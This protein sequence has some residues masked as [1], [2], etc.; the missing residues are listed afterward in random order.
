MSIINQIL[1]I[2]ALLLSVQ[3]YA[4]SAF[5]NGNVLYKEGKYKEAVNAYES[6]LDSGKESPEVYFNLGNAYYKLNAIAPSIY[7]Y[8]KAL[9]LKPNFKDAIIN[10]GYAEKMTIDN[11]QAVPEV[12][13]SKILYNFTGTYHYDTWAWAA[14]VCAVLF[15]LLFTGYYFAGTTM[16]KRIFFTGMILMLINIIITIISAFFVK[17]ESEKQQPAIVFDEV[18]SVK[19]EPN[20]TASDAF[21]LHEGTKVYVKETVGNFKKIELADDTVGWIQKDAIKELKL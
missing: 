21:I 8:E 20:K 10:L 13:F 14:I 16:L 9:L 12:G 1:F 17:S 7:N 18:T 2:I 6:I 4:Q 3:V 5:E 19:S 11:I 15:L